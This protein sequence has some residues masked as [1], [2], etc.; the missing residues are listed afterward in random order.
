MREPTELE[1]VMFIIGLAVG[2]VVGFL[3]AIK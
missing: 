2:Y 1:I 3:A